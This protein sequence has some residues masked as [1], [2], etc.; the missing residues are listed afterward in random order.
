MP[1]WY[2][3][4]LCAIHNHTR[5][6]DIT[7]PTIRRINRESVSDRLDTLINQ[8]IPTRQVMQ[9]LRSEG[10]ARAN[11]VDQDVWNRRQKLHYDRLASRL[12]IQALLMQLKE[13]SWDIEYLLEGDAP[14]F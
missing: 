13:G 1:K 7:H 5:S 9:I 3:D 4:V 12:P 10:G 8:K 6:P 14:T 2:I 11:I